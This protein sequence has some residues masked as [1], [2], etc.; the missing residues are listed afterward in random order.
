LSKIEQI[1]SLVYSGLFYLTEHAD[2]EATSDGFDIYDVEYALTTGK[3]RRSWPKEHKYEVIGKALDGS[4]IGIICR[5]TIGGK[6]RVITVY[7]DKP[8]NQN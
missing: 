3:I 6:V 2:F 8:E 1:R 4:T 5:I 7:E